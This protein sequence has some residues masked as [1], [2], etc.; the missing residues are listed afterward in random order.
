MSHWKCLTVHFD[1]FF[2]RLPEVR[3]SDNG[4]YECH[5]GIYDRATREK[6]VLA[7]GN[8]LLTVMCEYKCTAKMHRSVFSLHQLCGTVCADLKPSSIEM[9]KDRTFRIKWTIICADQHLA[10]CS[11]QKCCTQKLTY[12]L[13]CC[14]LARRL[15]LWSALSYVCYLEVCRIFSVRAWE[16]GPEWADHYGWLSPCDKDIW[17][18]GRIVCVCVSVC[19]CVFVCNS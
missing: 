7:S 14:L 8:V 4:P 3:I 16:F 19:F 17:M 1:L 9:N 11:W 13:L 6:V 12:N 5:V 18:G 15:W 2:H 10:L